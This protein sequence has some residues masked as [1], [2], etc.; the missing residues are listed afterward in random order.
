MVESAKKGELG[1]AALVLFIAIILVVAVTFQ[2]LLKTT[3]QVS[4]TARTSGQQVLQNVGTGITIEEAYGEDGT[5]GALNYFY[6]V[7]RLPAGSEDIQ[8]DQ[9]LV[10][11]NLAGTWKSYLY[12]NNINCTISD[13]TNFKSIYNETNA[14][15]YGV[16]F[17]MNTGAQDNEMNKSYI[18]SGD[19]I[20]ICFKSPTPV[21][22]NTTKMT[23]SVAPIKG[24]GWQIVDPAI[25]TLSQKTY[26]FF[27]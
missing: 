13:A 4:Q 18:K 23:I 5:Q 25:G 3:N 27:P 10:K 1:I 19:V 17:K 14:N 7:A 16:Y 11:M 8:F 26:Y 22:V 9:L 6:V 20:Q 2:V 15:M 24:N 21:N 12:S